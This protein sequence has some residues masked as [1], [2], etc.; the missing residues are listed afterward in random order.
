MRQYIWTILWVVA[1]FLQGCADIETNDMSAP[2]E[3]TNEVKITLSMVEPFTRTVWEKGESAIRVKW[4][5]FDYVYLFSLGSP[6]VYE[7]LVHLEENGEIALVPDS[8]TDRLALQ[9]G[10]EVYAVYGDSYFHK[11]DI[12]AQAVQVNF[13]S[14]YEYT[15]IYDP[16]YGKGVVKNGQ[17]SIAMNH[18][19]SFMK[20]TLPDE[21]LEQYGNISFD[22]SENIQP[23]GE[24][25]IDLKTGVCTSAYHYI[26]GFFKDQCME[27]DGV[28]VAYT[29]LIPT[30]KNVVFSLGGVEKRE[31]GSFNI[32]PL[33]SYSSRG[34][35]K[36][37]VYTYDFITVYEED[38]QNAGYESTD[39][40]EDGKVVKLQQA[41]VGKG[42]DLVFLG[43]GF[44]DKDLK[45]GGK[46]ER[47]VN[48]QIERLF[49]V[50]PFHSLRN[51]FNLYMV[52]VVSPTASWEEGKKHA[53]DENLDMAYYYIG[54]VKDTG[55]KR[56]VVVYNTDS[57]VGRSYCAF[58]SDRNF[59]CY[60]MDPTDVRL[61]QHEAGGHGFANLTDEYVEP[62]YEDL[63]YPSEEIEQF[64]MKFKLFGWY[65]NV[66]Y[67]SDA[68]T[69][70]W[71]A[72]LND[73]RYQNEHLGIFEGAD[74]YGHGM[75]RPREESIMR[76]QLLSDSYNAPSREQIYKR[77][78][79]ESEGESWT[80][81]YEDFVAFDAVSRT[82]M[83][84]RSVSPISPDVYDEMIRKFKANHRAPV[85]I[86]NSSD[87]KVAVR[88]PLR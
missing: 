75:Y 14:H 29:P 71:S 41:T 81:N 28:T 4:E 25:T 79:E 39:F 5:E 42:I 38:K 82:S 51:R 34:I 12:D 66:D 76:V 21:L 16:L 40:S 62:G 67:H 10:Q 52:K 54:K 8:F 33:K 48:T 61:I 43:D 63:A 85:I 1:L 15:H 50:E 49:E 69:V 22:T 11:N 45:E 58:N 73:T 32:K 36:G 83:Q 13:N 17:L 59:V 26:C 55:P 68:S 6:E 56:G 46:F 27:E 31:D 74:L 88:V 80:Y 72:F 2:V 78:M 9:E 18:V 87:K 60:L 35:K 47:A 57:S 70:R 65:A 3:S 7:Y 53:I 23:V 44:L 20:V 86:R 64:D 84:T 19:F 37:M 30:E 77:I 24:G